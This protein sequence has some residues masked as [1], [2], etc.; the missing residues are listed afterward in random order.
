[1]E[2]KVIALIEVGSEEFS[3][4]YWVYFLVPKLPVEQRT[5]DFCVAFVVLDLVY[6]FYHSVFFAA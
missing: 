6:L 3:D 5:R 2:F 1:M 4:M